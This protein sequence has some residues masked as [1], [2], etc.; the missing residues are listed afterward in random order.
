MGWENIVLSANIS[1]LDFKSQTDKTI[2]DGKD[3]TYNYQNIAVAKWRK[4]NNYFK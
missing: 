2:K 4:V 3:I 1:F